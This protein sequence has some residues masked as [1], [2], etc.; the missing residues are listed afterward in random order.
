M[1][2]EARISGINWREDLPL[3][4]PVSL[5]PDRRP[6]VQ[7]GAG[8]DR[9]DLPVRGR[10]DPGR[11]LAGAASRGAKRAGDVCR[12]W[13]HRGSSAAFQEERREARERVEE[14]YANQLLSPAWNVTKDDQA[15]RTAAREAKLTDE[16]EAKVLANRTKRVSDA[17]T[18]KIARIAEAEKVADKNARNWQISQ[19]EYQRDQA[20]RRRTTRRTSSSRRRGRSRARASSRSLFEYETYQIVAVVN[21]VANWNWLGGVNNDRPQ[22]VVKSVFNFFA[23]G[24]LWLMFHHPVYFILFALCS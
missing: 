21:G 16:L 11:G 6:S 24:P 22:G 23:V 8:A 3:H 18:V 2:E 7:A 14:N 1:A 17:D 15:A 19:A 4:Q 10:K 12:A 5:V 13:D 9:A 20:V